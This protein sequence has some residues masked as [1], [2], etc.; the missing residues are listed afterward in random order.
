MRPPRPQA[1]ARGFVPHY[2]L[3]AGTAATTRLQL[4]N[5]RLLLL[6]TL[7]SRYAHARHARAC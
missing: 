2:N 3:S 4:C 1:I 5:S 7:M 6:A